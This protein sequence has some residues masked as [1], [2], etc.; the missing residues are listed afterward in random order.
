MPI[1]FHE[2]NTSTFLT[3]Y[4][5]VM[6]NW[7]NPSRKSYISKM[8]KV[9]YSQK[10]KKKRH[11][12]KWEGKK[13]MLWCLLKSALRATL[14][15]SSVQPKRN[16]LTALFCLKEWVDD[17]HT[18]PIVLNHPCFLPLFSF[19]PFTTQEYF[20]LPYLYCLLFPALMFDIIF[21]HFLPLPLLELILALGKQSTW[22]KTIW[23][24]LE[25]IILFGE[26]D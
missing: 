10:K 6:F 13:S 15:S 20:F 22:I 19:H 18:P 1:N 7:K 16:K 11:R 2:T 9:Q 23:K 5:K 3:L 4:Q 17:Q 26:L 21:T 25:L 8:Y 14:H 24:I 12:R